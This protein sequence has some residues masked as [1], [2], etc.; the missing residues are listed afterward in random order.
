MAP[1]PSHYDRYKYEVRDIN[2]KPSVSKLS[3]GQ[4]GFILS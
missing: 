4:A 2:S 1:K 3:E